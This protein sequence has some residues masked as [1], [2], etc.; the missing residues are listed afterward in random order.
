MN[1]T[2]RKLQDFCFGRSS[3]FQVCTSEAD[4]PVS[5]IQSSSGI[6]VRWPHSRDFLKLTLAFLNKCLSFP[7][8]SSSILSISLFP[9]GIVVCLFVFP[10]LI[11]G[12]LLYPLFSIHI[13][14]VACSLSVY[15]GKHLAYYNTQNCKLTRFAITKMQIHVVFK[16]VFGKQSKQ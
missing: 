8:P 11:F 6:C 14:R 4:L 10:F 3:V 5:S 2:P 16:T 9:H 13:N 1:D 7:R 12:A 15:L